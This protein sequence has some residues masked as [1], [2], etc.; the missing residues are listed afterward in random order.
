MFL[1]AL[2]TSL[3]VS[4]ALQ[5]PLQHPSCVYMHRPESHY[6]LTALVLDEPIVDEAVIVILCRM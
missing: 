3:S 6:V 4:K 1:D 5:G 2:S